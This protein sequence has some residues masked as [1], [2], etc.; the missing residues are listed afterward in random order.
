MWLLAGTNDLGIENAGYDLTWDTATWWWRDDSIQGAFSTHFDTKFGLYA[1][2]GGTWYGMVL[3]LLDV[4]ESL[5]CHRSLGVGLYDVLCCLLNSILYDSLA[6]T[7]LVGYLIRY[8][9][10]VTWCCWNATLPQKSWS[11]SATMLLC[12]LLTWK[13]RWRDRDRCDCFAVMLCCSC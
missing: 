8:G 3:V 12:C 5:H 11:W 4:V 7:H 2:G 10:G 9:V 1:F 6:Y 13:R